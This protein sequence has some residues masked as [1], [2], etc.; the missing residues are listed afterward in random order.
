MFKAKCPDI[1]SSGAKEYIDYESGG[2]FWG[3]ITKETDAFCGRY[4]VK[5]PG[6]IFRKNDKDLGV[7][8]STSRQ[9]P[10]I[11]FISYFFL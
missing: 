1:L 9:V 6:R 5:N 3:S 8:V 2:K 11:P 10:N 4:S 7:A